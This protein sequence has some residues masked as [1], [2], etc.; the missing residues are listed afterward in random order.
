[1]RESVLEFSEEDPLR[2][3]VAALLCISMCSSPEWATAHPGGVDEC[4]CH[5]NTKTHKH[6]CHPK[7][8][9]TSCDARVTFTVER[10]PKAGDEGVLFGPYV[11]VV[12][13]D[14]FKVK[15]QGAVMDV[16]LQGI[17]APEIDQPFGKTARGILEQLIRGRQIVLVFD[18]VDH[19]GRIVARAWVGDVDVSFEMIRRGAAWFDSEYARD[20]ELYNEELKART[21]KHGLW[22]LATQDRIEPWV[23]RRSGRQ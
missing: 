4:G 22:S 21:A 10:P 15:V 13:G 16:R 11:S 7:R 12:D 14:S 20:D 9:K 5:R 19:Y 1:V 2:Y 17:D 23:W 3:L 18:D 6:H 8:A